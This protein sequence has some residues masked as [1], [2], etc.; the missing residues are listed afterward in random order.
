MRRSF[1]LIKRV[2]IVDD[3]PLMRNQLK[4]I[5]EGAGYEV[6]GEA[7]N[8]EEALVKFSELQPDLVTMDITMPVMDGIKGT[9]KICDYYPEANIVMVTAVS[10]QTMVYSAI[11]AGAKNYVLKPFKPE[12]VVQ[13]LNK[14]CPQY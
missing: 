11:K 4:K 6:V 7:Q 12:K 10:T 13:V 8:G 2:L 9:K 1:L 5:V 14:V 3:S